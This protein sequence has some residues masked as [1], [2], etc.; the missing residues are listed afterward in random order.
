VPSIVFA[1]PEPPIARDRGPRA[2]FDSRTREHAAP[3]IGKTRSLRVNRRC[4]VATAD[5]HAWDG[6]RIAPVPQT[7]NETANGTANRAVRYEVQSGVAWITLDQPDARNSLDAEVRRG[8]YESLG[9]AAAAD[10]VKVVVLTG[11]GDRVFCCGTDLDLGQVL[12]PD[13]RVPSPE[14]LP[15]LN[16]NFELP[17]P[18]IAA[19]NG[20]AHGAGLL[21]AQMCDLCIAARTASFAVPDVPG[22]PAGA[23]AA[24]LAWLVPPRVAMQL[25]VTGEVVDALR[26]R[27]IGLVN[28]VVS[29]S[30]LRTTVQTL[31]EQIAGNPGL[32]VTTA[33]EMVRAARTGAPGP[34]A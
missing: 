15:V 14:V 22:G 16:H 20:A 27:E 34:R 3:V 4:S 13:G 11:A 5:R 30:D 32:P 24:T 23:W 6:G 19:V 25:L 33:R 7:T 9:L 18:T 2:A 26:A 28:E 31:G 17:K 1:T 10:D 29:V 8:L 21:L 12:D